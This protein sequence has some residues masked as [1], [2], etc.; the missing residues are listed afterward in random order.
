M[1]ARV[2]FSLAPGAVSETV[3]VSASAALLNTETSTVGQVIDNQ[4]N[5]RTPPERPQLPRACSTN[6]RRRARPGQPVR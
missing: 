2:D 4:A 6:D 5:R 1:T 3:E